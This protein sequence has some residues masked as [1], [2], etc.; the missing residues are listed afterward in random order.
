MPEVR[1]RINTRN[2]AF[3]KDSPNDQAPSGPLG[4][5]ALHGPHYGARSP[6]G[7]PLQNEIPLPDLI[8]RRINQQFQEKGGENSPDQ[9]G[10]DPFHDVRARAGGPQDGNEAEEGGGYGH[11]LGPETPDRSVT[12]DF[13]QVGQG[14]EAP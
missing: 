8:D 2:A 9:R 13:L 10:G 4:E 14:S 7:P 3:F 1:R 5:W 11:E 12:D 6:I